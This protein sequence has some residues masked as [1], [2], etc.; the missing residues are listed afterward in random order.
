MEEDVQAPTG[1]TIRSIGNGKVRAEWKT[2]EN[3][4]TK[5]YV[6]EVM[7]NSSRFGT[8]NYGTTTNTYMDIENVPSGTSVFGVRAI[9]KGKNSSY[10]TCLYQ[11]PIETTSQPTTAQNLILVMNPEN[12]ALGKTAVASSSE[13]DGTSAAKAFDGD[14]ASRWASN[15]NDNEWISV[16]LGS[17]KQVYFLDIHWEAAFASTYEVYASTDGENWNLVNT[18]NSTGG[19]EA[20]TAYTRARYIKLVGKQRATNYG[21]SMYEMAVMAY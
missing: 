10:N 7:N 4:K 3:A 19:H 2:T 9:Y 20:V 12:K 6:Y 13:S 17:T 15:W 1:I 21:I 5:D 16:D 18:Y 8:T 14:L 11:A